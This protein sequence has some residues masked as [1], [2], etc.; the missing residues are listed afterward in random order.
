MSKFG[1]AVIPPPDVR[2]LKRIARFTEGLKEVYAQETRPR[3]NSGS[4]DYS[5]RYTSAVG[6][7]SR[8]NQQIS[9]PAVKFGFIGSRGGQRH[10]SES[11]DYWK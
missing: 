5:M 8:R 4:M 2:K 9:G 3:G 11:K 6:S 7:D 1:P 10:E